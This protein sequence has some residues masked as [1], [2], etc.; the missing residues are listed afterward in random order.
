MY[1]DSLLKRRQSE[2][3]RRAWME[4]VRLNPELA[5]YTP[6]AG[7]LIVNGGFETPVTN[8]GLD[9]RYSPKPGVRVEADTANLRS[10]AASL[11]ITFERQRV[12]ETGLHQ[13]VPVE[14]G[15][16][17]EFSGYL[18]TRSLEAAGGARFVVRDA[19]SGRLYFLSDGPTG[20]HAWMELHGAFRA[21]PETAVLAVAV[22]RV[23]GNTLA[24]G[25]VWVDDLRLSQSTGCQ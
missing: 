2:R 3:L 16:C 10:G 23:P 1:L 11:R 21:D 12:A 24:Q 9:W 20:T 22:A 17:Y 14:S 25:E 18:K 4:V 6:G 8:L 7:S 15:A 19:N 5:E 13:F